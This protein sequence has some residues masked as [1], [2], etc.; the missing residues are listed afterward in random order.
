MQVDFDLVV[1]K[2]KG[3]SCRKLSKLNLNKV[4]F[5]LTNSFWIPQKLSGWSLWELPWPGRLH[6]CAAEVHQPTYTN[7][8]MLC[9]PV[10]RSSQRC[11]ELLVT[12]CR[13]LLSYH[14]YGGYADLSW[15]VIWNIISVIFSPVNER[16]THV[17]RLQ[18]VCESFGE[19][20]WRNVW[21]LLNETEERSQIQSVANPAGDCGSW[22][23]KCC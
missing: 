6:V 10:E 20:G 11:V 17:A 1:K 5:W 12:V 15:S 4:E 13:H 8:I 18:T 9:L 21:N 19:S 14:A 7:I 3:F 16:I 22:P 23:G 2:K